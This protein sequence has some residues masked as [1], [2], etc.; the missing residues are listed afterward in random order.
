MHACACVCVCV[1][2][3]ACVC[4]CVHVCACVCMCVHVCACVCMCVFVCDGQFSSIR[5]QHTVYTYT[6]PA[7]I[8][9]IKFAVISKACFT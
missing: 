5:L 2:V 7:T 6:V 3:C 9:Y 8:V 4:M 1:L